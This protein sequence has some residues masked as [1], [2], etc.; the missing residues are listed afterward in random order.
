MVGTPANFISN[1]RTDFANEKF[2]SMAEEFNIRVKTTSSESA[3]SKSICKR[4]NDILGEM[5]E[6]IIEDTNCSL[7]VALAWTNSMK[8][9]MQTI[10][11]FSLAQLVFGY[12]PMLPTVCSRKPPDLGTESAYEHMVDE[13]LKAQR[14]A[15]LRICEQNH[16]KE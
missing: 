11:G 14:K 3:W 1:N 9:T 8:N 16:L 12:N 2:V 4:Y 13:N 7:T 10:H 5:A 6:K 15:R